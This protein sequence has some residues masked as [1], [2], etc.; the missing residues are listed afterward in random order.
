MPAG[1]KVSLEFYETFGLSGTAAVTSKTIAAPIERIKMVSFNVLI[2]DTSLVCAREKNECDKA[3][4]TTVDTMVDDD[5]RHL[6]W[7][8]ARLPCTTHT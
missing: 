1:K 7:R 6:F 2:D 8:R 3:T 4:N 5:G